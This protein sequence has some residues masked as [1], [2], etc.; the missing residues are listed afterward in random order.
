[1]AAYTLLPTVAPLLTL[2]VGHLRGFMLLSLWM[3]KCSSLQR[4]QLF[5]NSIWTFRGE[6]KKREG[7]ESHQANQLPTKWPCYYISRK[8]KKIRWIILR[9]TSQG[10]QAPKLISQ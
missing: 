7:S 6:K 5:R 2:L 1:M 4:S 10:L 8:G 9:D 3:F